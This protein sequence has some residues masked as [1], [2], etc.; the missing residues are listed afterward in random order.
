MH[1]RT[2]IRLASI[3]A[4]VL[5][6]REA[7]AQPRWQEIGKTSSGNPVYVDARSVKR[8]NVIVNA[9]I[10]VRFL[11]PVHTQRGDVRSSRALAM[12]DCGRRVAATKESFLYLDERG[13]RESQHTINKLPGYSSPIVGTPADVALKHFCPA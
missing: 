12:L 8:T 13:T 10:R 4:V 9:T 7:R 6:A 11:T 5:A 3:G 2:F 1:L